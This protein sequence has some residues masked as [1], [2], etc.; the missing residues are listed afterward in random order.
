MFDYPCRGIR[1]RRCRR[2]VAGLGL[3]A[4]LG[5]I[6]QGLLGIFRVK[7]N[8]L[9]GPDLAFVHGCFAQLVFAL[10]VSDAVVTSKNYIE[11]NGPSAA[12]NLRPAALGLV[13]L[14]DVQIVFGALLRHLDSPVAARLHLLAA[15]GVVVV[16][17]WL[18]SASRGMARP[19]VRTANVLA[20]LIVL[21]LML[22][23]EAW[24]ARMPVNPM[25]VSE[26]HDLVRSLHHFTGSLLF[27][28]AVTLAWQA[29]RHTMAAPAPQ[30]ATA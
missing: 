9:F 5:V 17:A 27:A 30:E 11:S 3:L 24:L 18:F 4:L 20:V 22:G 29:Y 15:F 16:A 28:A 2:W 7:L 8:S 12:R 10:L 25:A 21:Q 13:V 14:V 19:V 1:S 26:G 6:A 23:V